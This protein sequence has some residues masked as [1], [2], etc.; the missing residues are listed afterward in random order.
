[1]SLPHL[2]DVPIT[3]LP[4]LLAA[5]GVTNPDR[6]ARTIGLAIHRAGATAIDE[7]P[8]GKET[9][10]R[11]AAA[12]DFAPLLAPVGVR[13]GADGATRKWMFRLASGETIESVL[14]RH[15]DN[16]TLCISTQAGCAMA[17]SFCATGTMGLARNLAPG[18]ISEQIVRVQKD[19]QVRVTDIVFMG[20]GEPLHNYDS[21][22]TACVNMNERAGHGVSRRKITVST[23]G[24]VPGIRRFTAEKQGWRLHLSLHSAIQRTREMLMPIAR[25]HPLPELL[26]AMREHQR[27]LAVKWL[28][29]QYVAIPGV[30]MD[31]DHVDALRDELAGMRYILDVIPWND[32]GGSRRA[33]DH[34]DVVA[35]GAGFRAPTWDEVKEFTTKLRALAC[36]VKVR[37]SAGKQDGMG[38][39]QLSAETVAAAPAHVGSHMAAPPG[40]FTR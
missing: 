7:I 36:P 12:F 19:A 11:L 15:W 9:R 30:N 18:E 40:I 22:M 32:F 38:C 6:A 31:Q 34:E 13:A 5:A 4:P 26:D 10:A 33:R 20:M 16:H 2:R 35:R 24:L 23:A 8:V 28:T 21:V 29:F 37:Y 25:V 14:I 17:C 39:G 3:A 27:E 1:M